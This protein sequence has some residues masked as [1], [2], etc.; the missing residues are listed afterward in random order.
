MVETVKKKKQYHL[1]DFLRGINHTNCPDWSFVTLKSSFV[2]GRLPGKNGNYHTGIKALDAPRRTIATNTNWQKSISKTKNVFLN[3]FHL[4]GSC[5]LHPQTQG[6]TTKKNETSVSV[7]VADREAANAAIV[8]N[9][10]VALNPI[11]DDCA[12]YVEGAQMV[13]AKNGAG[14]DGTGRPIH[15]EPTVRNE[16]Q[17]WW[18]GEAYETEDYQEGVADE[19][20]EQ[21]KKKA[22]LLTLKQQQQLL[23]RMT[24]T[25]TELKKSS[26]YE[27]IR[28]RRKE[29]EAATLLL[30][31][32][33]HHYKERT[34]EGAATTT[35]DDERAR[36]ERRRKEEWDKK[37]EEA[38]HVQQRKE[39]ERAAMEWKT[40]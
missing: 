24:T 12:F 16:L 4:P 11:D 22:L 39:R 9:A 26:A 33:H 38:R 20:E 10:M 23:S 30:L 13:H 40:S 1:P 21:K 35:T 18:T 29:K 25:T 36:K 2:G 37:T 17:S 14:G 34:T 6:Y 28:R 19:E 5:L 15:Q 3:S 8:A 32:T 7:V 31:T 27:N